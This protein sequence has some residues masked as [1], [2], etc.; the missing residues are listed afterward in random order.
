MQG[1]RRPGPVERRP[2]GQEAD[3][4]AGPPHAGDGAHERAAHGQVCEGA[5][6]GGEERD[7]AG[8]HGQAG[9]RED[10]KVAQLPRGPSPRSASVSPAISSGGVWNG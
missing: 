3:G 2:G 9:Q 1:G 5:P 4:E 10:A 8:R 6:D 7:A